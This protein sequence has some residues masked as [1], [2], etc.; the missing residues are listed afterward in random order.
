MSNRFQDLHCVVTGAARGIGAA[1]AGQLKAE[2]AVIHAADILDGS[3]DVT[4][5]D[6][7]RAFF[8]SVA[9]IDKLI[10]IAGGLSSGNSESTTIEQWRDC[11]A[12]NL[13][14]VWLCVQAA[15]PKLRQSKCASLTFAVRAPKWQ[16]MDLFGA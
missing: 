5:P 13:E 9:A 10:C 6:S 3:C 11:Q 12:L 4:N 16:N 2:G 1:I 8:Q 14:S 15:I 7:V